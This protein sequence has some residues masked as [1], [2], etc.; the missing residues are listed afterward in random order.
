MAIYLKISI[1]D[2]KTESRGDSMDKTIEENW[3]RV[4]TNW[5]LKK[6]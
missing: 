6:L 4:K 3:K 2:D 1:Q 5:I